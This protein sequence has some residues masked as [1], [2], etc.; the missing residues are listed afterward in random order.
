MTKR[1]ELVNELLEENYDIVDIINLVWERDDRS[2]CKTGDLEICEAV[3]GVMTDDEI[4][5]VL[6]EIEENR[7]EEE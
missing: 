2:R 3:V 7:E 5:N 1:D 6:K 4:D